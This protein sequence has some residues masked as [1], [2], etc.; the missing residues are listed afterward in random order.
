MY[1]C[2]PDNVAPNDTT[3]FL[4][5][6]TPCPRRVSPGRRTQRTAVAAASGVVIVFLVREFGIVEYGQ[7]WFDGDGAANIGVEATNAGDDW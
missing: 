4:G 5:L 3:T 6:P 7:Q 2:S 1:P